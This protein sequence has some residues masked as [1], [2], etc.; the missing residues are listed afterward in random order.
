MD[1]SQQGRPRHI[2]N[3]IPPTP[4]QG[5]GPTP[6][7]DALR[8]AAQNQNLVESNLLQL[9]DQQISSGAPFLSTGRG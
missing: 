2:H 6:T 3:G 9:L 4:R 8:R 1:V 5:K 7:Q